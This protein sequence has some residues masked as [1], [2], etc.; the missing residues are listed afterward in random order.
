V[1]EYATLLSSLAALMSSLTMLGHSIQVPFTAASGK[2]MAAS[3]SRAHGM[4]GPSGTAAYAGAPYRRP[5]LRYL[6]S[7]GWVGAAS[8]IP[9]CKAALLL[10]G[11]PATAA[12]KALQQ[13]PALLARLRGAHVT[14]S[15]ASA[16]VA[17]GFEAGC[18]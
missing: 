15:Q 9:A 11:D 7:V 4:P 12:A 2:L 8:N 10:G 6:Y 5:A 18:R 17:S 3:L 13:S 14:A 16:A 1:A